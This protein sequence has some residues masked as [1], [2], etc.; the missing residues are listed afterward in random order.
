MKNPFSKKKVNVE[1]PVATELVQ[2]EEKECECVACD[3]LLEDNPNQ[4]VTSLSEYPNWTFEDHPD[5]AERLLANKKSEKYSLSNFRFKVLDLY[6][7]W[8][9]S[10]SQE[11]FDKKYKNMFGSK[12]NQIVQ[13]F[14]MFKDGED[15]RVLEL[16]LG[17]Y[18]EA[19]NKNIDD[20]DYDYGNI[21][22]YSEYK[23][24]L[25]ADQLASEGK[26][27]GDFNNIDCSKELPNPSDDKFDSEYKKETK[28]DNVESI[29]HYEKIINT[30]FTEK[31]RTEFDYVFS[32]SEVKKIQ[33]RLKQNNQ[34]LQTYKEMISETS[35]EIDKLSKIHAK[36][37]YQ[38]EVSEECS[39]Y[40]DRVTNDS[41]I[42]TKPNHQ[43]DLILLCT[44]GLDA[45]GL[46]DRINGLKGKLNQLEIS[47][48]DYRREIYRDEELLVV[49]VND[50]GIDLINMECDCCKDLNFAVHYNGWTTNGVV[51]RNDGTIEYTRVDFVA[52]ED[53]FDVKTAFEILVYTYYN[54]LFDKELLKTQFLQ[55]TCCGDVDLNS[56]KLK[57]YLNNKLNN[58]GTK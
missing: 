57:C 43:D 15:L 37:N 40:M 48:G 44:I 53:D 34:K 11:S 50:V 55:D 38:E 18:K 5:D 30:K 3:K 52:E 27:V 33:N 9:N 25:E 16:N 22:I 10:E 58:K 56:G 7:K 42:T 23:D 26:I 28:S 12:Y 21:K 13:L 2:S 47:L 29:K 4:S 35:S 20:S 49:G 1:P 54:D 36:I 6:E 14:V 45:K 24:V 17:E 32:V 51:Y 8:F 31:I 41:K 19:D 46:V 39:M